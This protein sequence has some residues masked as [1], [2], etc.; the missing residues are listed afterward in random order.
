MK[1]NVNNGIKI[2][3]IELTTDGKIGLE[4]DSL[5]WQPLIHFLLCMLPRNF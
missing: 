1:G 2:F 4:G 3:D 5:C